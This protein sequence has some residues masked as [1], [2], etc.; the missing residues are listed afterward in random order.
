MSALRS[1]LLC[2]SLL[3]AAAGAEGSKRL[4]EAVREPTV[5]QQE[6]VRDYCLGQGQVSF[7]DVMSRFADMRLDTLKRCGT[8]IMSSLHLLPDLGS[9]QHK[10]LAQA[11][12]AAADGRPA[13]EGHPRQRRVP[14]GLSAGA[15]SGICAY[16]LSCMPGTGVQAAAC[17]LTHCGAVC[18]CNAA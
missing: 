18:D 7:T 6:A 13:A 9:A 11:V 12:P 17:S 10:E 2:A 15:A 3:N 16:V 5:S 1:V 8:R 4:P 14:G